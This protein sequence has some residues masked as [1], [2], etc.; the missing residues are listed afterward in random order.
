MLSTGL[1]LARAALLLPPLALTAIAQPQESPYSPPGAP[2]VERPFELTRAELD[3][4]P[5]LEG[6]YE[7]WEDRGARAGRILGLRVVVVPAREE[8]A[9]EDP[10]FF[11]AGGPGQG[12]AELAGW[13]APTWLSRHRDL[14]LVDQRGTGQSNPL[15]CRL[16]GSLLDPQGLLDALPPD[17][18]FRECLEELSQRADLRLYSTP[19]AVDD[20]NEIR[21]ALG[22]GKINLF[23]GSY[24][25]R[26][27]LVYM[28]RHPETVRCAVLEGVAP[29]GLKNPLFHASSA[30]S[31]L[32]RILAEC[33]ANPQC[34]AA[35]GDLAA[36]LDA[37]LARLADEPASLE[38]P[39]TGGRRT[40]ALSRDTFAEALRIQ[41]Y[42]TRTSRRI[43]LTIHKAHA[44][45]FGPVVQLALT[46]GLALR[47]SVAVGML[48]SVTCAEDVAR[49]DPADV[50]QETRGTFLGDTRV[51]RQMALCEW[52]PA[53][54]LP[55]DYG[56]P[57]TCEAPVL[58]VSGALD[59]VTPP[60]FAEEAART[61]PNS[62][63]V[64]LP[65]AHSFRGSCLASIESRFL[66]AGNASEL[67]T[68]CVAG[69]SLPG[70]E[71]E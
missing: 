29:L 3:G 61:L 9:R 46:R 69:M 38:V 56:E 42:D 63:H 31:A 39:F 28:R 44:G 15:H 27:A 65:T 2:N 26:A 30:Q 5:I 32:E 52:W 41:M 57:V 50:E 37:V 66:D 71:L 43:P 59:P 34:N 20:L 60:V 12:A 55:E 19:I 51:L 64:V 16:P 18:V 14:V 53:G 1:W 24:G 45:D 25:T 6:T 21:A 62:L 48:L 67:D 58:L 47:K 8:P 49:I 22:Y 40:V 4:I 23:G 17:E 11:L 33:A 70:F 10:I 68:E 13:L 35:F 36:K 54:R 7:V